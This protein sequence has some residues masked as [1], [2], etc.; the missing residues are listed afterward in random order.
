MP[1]AVDDWRTVCDPFPDCVEA[2]TT[3][4]VPFVAGRKTLAVSVALSEP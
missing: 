1:E 2:K 3:S 4:T